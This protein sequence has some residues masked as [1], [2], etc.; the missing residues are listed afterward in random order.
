MSHPCADPPLRRRGR[1]PS[2][3]ASLA[4]L[5][6]AASCEGTIQTHDGQPE[7]AEQFAVGAT[8]TSFD[9]SLRPE[10]TLPGPPAQG[11]EVCGTDQDEAWRAEF[12]DH[13][14][15]DG[16]VTLTL[17]YAAEYLVRKIR[18]YE[19]ANPGAVVQIRLYEEGD[20]N[21]PLIIAVE[22]PTSACPGVLEIELDEAE[23]IPSSRLAVV[24]DTTVHPGAFEEIDTVTLWDYEVRQ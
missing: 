16:L 2:A 9:L 17:E 20:P 7:W 6:F 10:D 13:P 22:D 12:A 3:L 5:A 18:V 19:G 15:G 21:Q 8:A 11:D 4:A 14:Q 24:I 1:G 23:Q